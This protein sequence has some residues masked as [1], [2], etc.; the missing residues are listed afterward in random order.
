MDM[1]DAVCVLKKDLAGYL[2]Q[3]KPCT[4]LK[5][6]ESAEHAYVMSAGD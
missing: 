3:R 1:M 2:R 5:P 6:R 4:L